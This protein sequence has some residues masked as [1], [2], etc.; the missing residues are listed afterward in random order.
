MEQMC[1]VRETEPGVP[2]REQVPTHGVFVIDEADLDEVSGG[3]GR[4]GGVIGDRIGTY[5]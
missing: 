1:Q 2:A 4:A 3:G 5:E